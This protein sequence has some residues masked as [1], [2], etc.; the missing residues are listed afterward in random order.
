[1]GK[2]LVSKSTAARCW[3][4]FKSGCVWLQSRSNLLGRSGGFRSAFNRVHSFQSMKPPRVQVGCAIALVPEA[5]HPP[6]L[7]PLLSLAVG[8]VSEQDFPAAASAWI[9]HKSPGEHTKL[10]LSSVWTWLLTGICWTPKTIF[11]SRAFYSFLDKQNCETRDSTHKWK[12][13]HFKSLKAT[14]ILF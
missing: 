9:G 11:L 12:W 7:D 6:L 8:W 5:P 1:M 2:Q 3:G 10:R 4:R 13:L 14:T